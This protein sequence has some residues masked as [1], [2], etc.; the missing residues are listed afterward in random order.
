MR[1][2]PPCERLYHGSVNKQDGNGARSFGRRVAT[3]RA[4]VEEQSRM[5]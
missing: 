5:S 1:S 4:A 2:R 3:L